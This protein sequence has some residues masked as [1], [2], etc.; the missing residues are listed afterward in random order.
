MK[1]LITLILLLPF[2]LL[3]VEF[4]VSPMLIEVDGVPNQAT[5]FS[6][7]VKAKG[8]GD[9]KLTP[10]ALQQ[11][12]TGHMDFT[13]MKE[14]PD[15][16]AH[17]IRLDKTTYKLAKDQNQVIKGKLNVPRKASGNYLAAV[18]VEEVAPK[19]KPN[20]IV[21]KVRYAVV[22]N[23][24]V[25]G[26]KRARFAKTSL[27]GLNYQFKENKPELTAWFTNNSTFD[28][29]LFSEVQIR[30]ENRRLV[31]RFPLKT[32]SAWQRKENGSRVYPK[33]KVKLIAN[34]EKLLPPGTYIAMVRSKFGKRPQPLFRQQ[35][36]IP[37]LT[38]SNTVTE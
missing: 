5:E 33:A 10:F 9:I 19:N 35:I 4:S 25:T 27:G 2:S 18:M 38:A 30:D 37:E 13:Q 8:A 12:E 17:W 23:V 32:L 6:F 26:R 21:V 11:Q 15:S 22:I 29:F 16:S 36:V 34:M 31:A 20:G 7:N 28:D 3:A 14:L 24:K 1:R